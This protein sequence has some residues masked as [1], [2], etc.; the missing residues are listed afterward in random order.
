M[1][2]IF[3]CLSYWV[4]ILFKFV[5]IE[6]ETFDKNE[7]KTSQFIRYGIEVFV[8]IANIHHI[9]MAVIQNR[10]YLIFS[11]LW[12]GFIT[13]FSIINKKSFDEYKKFYIYNVF[14]ILIEILLLIY[15]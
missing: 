15:L 3:T 6:I 13:W 12:L 1:T 5:K 4:Y 10:Y 9:I 2:C 8:C 14:I 11:I 7:D